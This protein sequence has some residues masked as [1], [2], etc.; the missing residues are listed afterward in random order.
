LVQGIHPSSQKNH[1]K[2]NIL[3]HMLTL[4]WSLHLYNDFKKP[5]A[6]MVKWEH[7]QQFQRGFPKKEK[8]CFQNLLKSNI[9]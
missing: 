3:L 1:Y 5:L 9:C 4:F 2:H 7:W 6:I 8:K